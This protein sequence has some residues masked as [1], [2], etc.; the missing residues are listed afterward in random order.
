M[1]DT[2]KGLGRVERDITIY[3]DDNEPRGFALTYEEDGSTLGIDWESTFERI[4]CQ[5][6]KDTG[7][8][9]VLE[10]DSDESGDLEFVTEVIEGVTYYFMF[11]PFTWEDTRE[12]VH[13]TYRYDVECHIPDGD[14]IFKWTP[15]FGTIRRTRDVTRTEAS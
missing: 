10:Y 7:K 1:I 9:V 6:R 5:V 4:I 15:I 11:V 2:I 14:K 8:A 12:L 3:T 13:D